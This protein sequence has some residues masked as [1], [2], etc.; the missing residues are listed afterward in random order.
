MKH[1]IVGPI[2]GDT[3]GLTASRQHSGARVKILW[4][5][6]R[7]SSLRRAEGNERESATCKYG[8][9]LVAPR[10]EIGN[11]VKGKLEMLFRRFVLF[12]RNSG[13][14]FGK[15]VKEKL[16][17]LFR[18]LVSFA[19]NVSPNRENDNKDHLHR[20]FAWPH[21]MNSSVAMRGP[22]AA[23]TWIWHRQHARWHHGY[24]RTRR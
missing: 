18:R 10:N 24:Y 14:R 9:H 19:R 6:R 21:V 23:G 4:K 7:Q 5:P 8:R 22:I 17:M 2:I 12:A 15:V 3:G 20:Q 16:V 13:G 1:L 11:V